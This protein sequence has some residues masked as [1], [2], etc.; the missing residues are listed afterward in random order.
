MSVLEG[1][2]REILHSVVRDRLRNE[3]ETAED[4]RRN[5]VHGLQDSL[6]RPLR[7]RLAVDVGGIFP[8][9]TD[10]GLSPDV[11]SIE[12]TL[13]NVE[14]S[15][16]DIVS[17]PLEAKGT[18]VRGGVLVAM[19]SYLALNANRGMV[20]ALEE[21]EAFLHPAAQEMLRDQLEELASAQGV[22]LLVTT[23][24]PFIMT[25]SA[26][27]RVFCLA[28]DREGRT[29]LSEQARGDEDHAPLIGDL[30]REITVESLLASSTELPADAEAVVLVEG[31]GDKFCL[32]LAASTVGRPELLDGIVI[33]P[34]GGTIKMIAHAVITRAATDLPLLIL[35][36]N[37]APGREPKSR[38]VGNT[39]GFNKNQF[40]NYSNVFDSGWAQEPVEAEDVFDPQ[41]I[42][43]FVQANGRSIIAGSKKRPD[44]MFHYDLDSTAKEALKLWL[45]ERTRPHHVA[46][47]INLLLLLR[48]RAGLAAIGDTAEAIVAAADDNSAPTPLADGLGNVMIVT[49]QHDYAR[50]HSTGA[51]TIDSSVEIPESASHVAF[52]SRVIQPHIP[53][54]LADHPNRLFAEST[55]AQLRATGHTT[56]AVVANVIEA[57][58]RG[59]SNL[60]GTSQRV[61]V[62]STPDSSETIVLDEPI[63]NTK[64]SKGRP[65]AWTI[66][67]KVVPVAALAS[68]P[69]TTTELD[70]LIA[71]G[72]Q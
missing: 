57:A 41:L 29:R 33:R 59:D 70:K 63:E 71:E 36:D 49:G 69:R 7:D 18:G 35:T 68:G 58:I 55:C 16:A 26:N 3:F 21:P 19:L 42:E 44:G 17:T 12:Q 34:T 48:E 5:Y 50:Y 37:D 64:S 62:L 8:E 53:M 47:W 14:V 40:I 24:S 25:R 32:E 4:S 10:I 61:L 72:Q 67:P 15:V 54:I 2:F 43:D 13:S 65:I 30:L 38:L 52:Y 28:K 23:H 22:S 46:R 1:N 11:S 60:V 6:L 27:G 66:G 9:I 39:F 56:D 20:F 31:E 51:I 45:S